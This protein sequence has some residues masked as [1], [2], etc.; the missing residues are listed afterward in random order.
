MRC[1][2][3]ADIHANL[4]ALTAVLE[5]ISLK[6]KVDEICCLGDI[7]GYG[8]DPG[9]CIKLLKKIKAFCVGGNHDF[10]SIGRIEYS[11]FN[12]VA[13]EACE[14]TA[15]HM[16]AADYLFLSELPETIVKGDFTLVHG[17]PS[18]HLFEYIMS[19]SSAQKNFS[20][21]ETAICLV[22]HTHVP[23]AYRLDGNRVVTVPLLPGVGL[24]LGKQRLIINPGA[25]GQPRDGDP[26]ASYAIYDSDGGMFRLYRVEYDIRATQD[27]MMK[28]GLPT[29]L[30]MRLETGK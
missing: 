20:F 24:L 5:D 15:N 21:Y 22:G 14:W 2:I 11:Y 3:L 16:N 8:P 1:A 23:V 4:E 13:A 18:S 6:G 10:G 29:P 17:S 12:P 26:R 28:A 27:K 19:T 30:V 25:V 7:V 9:A